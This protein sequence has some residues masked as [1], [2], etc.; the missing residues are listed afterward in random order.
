MSAKEPRGEY[1]STREMLDDLP[2]IIMRNYGE[3]G[4]LT[5]G[6]LVKYKN[7]WRCSDPQWF[8][9]HAAFAGSWLQC[10]PDLPPKLKAEFEAIVFVAWLF[11]AVRSPQAWEARQFVAR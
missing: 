3:A 10:H 11:E 1:A 8:A 9:G 7:G 4:A 2:A 6:G 5:V